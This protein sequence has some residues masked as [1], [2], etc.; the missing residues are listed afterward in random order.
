[1]EN[2]LACQQEALQDTPGKVCIVVFPTELP[3]EMMDVKMAAA[4][5]NGKDAHCHRWN[6]ILRQLEWGKRIA[7]ALTCVR[8]WQREEWESWISWFPVPT[9]FNTWR[10]LTPGIMP[11]LQVSSDDEEHQP[12]RVASSGSESPGDESEMSGE[13]FLITSG[14]QC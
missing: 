6:G 2:R 7:D 14:E 11:P 10:H 4:R 1:M 3:E 12:L 5:W 9:M 13:G 8:R